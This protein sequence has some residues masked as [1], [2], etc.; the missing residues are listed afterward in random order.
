[1]RRQL[2]HQVDEINGGQ[3]RPASPGTAPDDLWL[4]W[5]WPQMNP[6]IDAHLRDTVEAVAHVRANAT[7]VVDDDQLDALLEAAGR[8]VTELEDRRDGIVE[9]ELE[10]DR[11]AFADRNG[12]RGADT[13]GWE[14][15]FRSNRGDR[16]VGTAPV[17]QVD[18]DPIQLRELFAG[19]HERRAT[20]A[21]RPD[22]L[23]HLREMLVHDAEQS[24][25]QQL[26]HP[27]LHQ[28]RA[29]AHSQAVHT[30]QGGIAGLSQ[31]VTVDQPD[32]LRYVAA[33]RPS[34]AEAHLR[35]EAPAAQAGVGSPDSAPAAS[36]GP[37]EDWGAVADSIDERIAESASWPRLNTA[38][39]AAAS[40]GWTVITELPA[41]VAAAPLPDHDAAGELYY[42]LLNTGAAE[43]SADTGAGAAH[44]PSPRPAEPPTYGN[45]APQ[46]PSPGV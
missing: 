22:D 14:T 38:L 18:V 27:E 23:N 33:T 40:N 37:E 25:Q 16:G 32:Q 21:N 30:A 44:Q 34:P 35:S 42:R 17:E 19:A 2:T 46:P 41:L 36:G 26:A 8:A 12:R 45:E 29:A 31:T 20:A 15:I 4:T 24:R 7:G 39:Q 6:A 5:Q 13:A 10:R 28:H 11:H 43:L 1:V 3:G 9:L